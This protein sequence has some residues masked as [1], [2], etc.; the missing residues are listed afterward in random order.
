MVQTE[1]SNQYEVR[2][3]RQILKLCHQI[4][5]G[6]HDNVLGPRMFTN[7]Q[8][9][10]LIVLFH[11]SGKAL[12]KFVGELPESRWVFWLGLRSLPSKSALH[13]W[14]KQFDLS[15][16]RGLISEFLVDET[17]S[18]MAVDATGVDSWQRSRHYER[19][20][21]ECGVRE[22]HL[23]YAKV[24]VLVDTDT[25]MIHDFVLRTKPRHDVLGATTMFKRAKHKHVLVLGDRGY[26][27][28]PLHEI[29]AEKLLQFYAPVRD[30]HVKKPSGKHRRRCWSSPPAKASRRSLVESAIRSLKS[31]FKSLRSRLHFLK[32]RELA[33]HI[34]IHN[35]ERASVQSLKA[36]LTLL[37]RAA[38]WTEPRGRLCP[39]RNK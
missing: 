17:P 18:L 11:R 2:L 15:F 28:E 3:H 7:F 21:K 6:Q 36:L 20:I 16:L 35:M 22:T 8:R 19:R 5:L 9:L 31:R 32:K 4:E 13:L 10:A 1:I 14:M 29:A 24:D 25:L 34:L 38:F 26:D 33:W 23:P 37:K 30:F 39:E 12:R 27:S